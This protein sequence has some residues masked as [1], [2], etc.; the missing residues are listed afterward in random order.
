MAGPRPLSPEASRALDLAKAGM[1]IV[2]IARQTGYS[3][4]GARLILKRAGV[5]AGKAEKTPPANIER[6]E[7]IASMYRQGL[8]LEKVGQHFGITRERVRQILKKEGLSSKDGGQSRQVAHRRIAKIAKS[9]AITLA[10]WGF[11]SA[12]MKAFRENGTLKA[13]TQQ[14]SNSRSRGVRWELTFSQWIAVWRESGKLALRGRGKGRYVMS[15]VKD[16]GGYVMGNVHVQLST[17]NNSQGIA[18]ARHNK[19]KHTGVWLILP[20]TAKPWQAA[21]GH[22]KL[23]YFATEDEAIAARAAYLETNPITRGRGYTL[24]KGKTTTRYQVMVGKRYVG[25]FKTPEDALIARQAAIF[26]A[27]QPAQAI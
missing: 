15:R 9:D 18:K 21:A 10:R 23:G 14:K 26:A 19:A 20:G 5:P 27:Q 17:D 3:Y 13:Y 22:K 8:P 24:I 12:E 6:A 16:A 7:K 1:P 4:C 25:T 2:E 11:S